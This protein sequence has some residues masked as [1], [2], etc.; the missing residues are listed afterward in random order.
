LWLQTR[1]RRLG[2]LGVHPSP[3]IRLGRPRPMGTAANGLLARAACVARCTSA[4]VIALAL[5]AARNLLVLLRRLGQHQG[6]PAAGRRSPALRRADRRNFVV[7]VGKLAAH[8]VAHRF[9]LVGQRDKLRR[10]LHQHGHRA[11]PPVFARHVWN[12]AVFRLISRNPGL[13]LRP[14]GL[15]RRVL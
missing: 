9:Q 1:R 2:R 8:G 4:V 5:S 15:G 12:G 3:I 6:S 11:H 10:Q 13:A 7:A 14:L